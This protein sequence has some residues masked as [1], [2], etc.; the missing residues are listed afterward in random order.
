MGTVFPA[1]PQTRTIY[2]LGANA[3]LSEGRNVVWTSAWTF[4][5]VP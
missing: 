5:P 1:T 3:G 4:T 2:A